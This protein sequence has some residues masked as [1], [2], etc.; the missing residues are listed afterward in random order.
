MQSFMELMDFR[1]FEPELAESA[2][3]RAA[4][5]CGFCDEAKPL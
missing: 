2:A 5:H 4:E 3:R 1:L